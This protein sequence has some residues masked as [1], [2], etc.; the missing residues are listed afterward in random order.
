MKTLKTNF[1]T[2]IKFT[3][4][5]IG[6]SGLSGQYQGL[7]VTPHDPDKYPHGFNFRHGDTATLLSSLCYSW[8]YGDPRRTLSPA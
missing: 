4:V 5:Q 7:P 2:L 3:F 8:N 6:A 1:N